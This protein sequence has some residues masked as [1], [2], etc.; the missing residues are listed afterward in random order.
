MTTVNSEKSTITCIC[1]IILIER[2]RGTH[3]YAAAKSKNACP[4][5][6]IK[7]MW[8]TVNVHSELLKNILLFD[9]FVL[10]CFPLFVCVIAVN[11][12]YSQAIQLV[13]MPR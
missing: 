3:I 7:L 6:R 12:Q 11:V 5:Q 2:E 4:T 1:I 10:F 8:W 9:I 13:Y